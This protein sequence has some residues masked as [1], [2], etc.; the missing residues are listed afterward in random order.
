MSGKII[1]EH[2][3]CPVCHGTG[4]AIGDGIEQPCHSGPYQD[5]WTDNKGRL[6][7]DRSCPNCGD[8]GYVG[9]GSNDLCNCLISQGIARSRGADR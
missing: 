5:S 4:G 8:N 1:A 7:I 9:W 3:T 6:V 2:D